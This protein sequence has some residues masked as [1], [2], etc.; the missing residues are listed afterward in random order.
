M[1]MDYTGIDPFTGE[2]VHTARNLGDRKLQ[3]ALLQFF[4]PENHFEVRKALLAAGRGDLIGAHCDALI[5]PQ[6][7]RAALRARQEKARRDLSEGRYVPIPGSDAGKV[8][9]TAAPSAPAR[10]GY[11]PGRTTARR[12]LRR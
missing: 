3:R 7:P 11:Q 4:K 6:P 2:E 1:C 8:G 5:P 12:R 9:S 10:P